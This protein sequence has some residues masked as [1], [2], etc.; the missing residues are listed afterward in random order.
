[1]KYSSAANMPLT[2][3]MLAQSCFAKAIPLLRLQAGR[4]GQVLHLLTM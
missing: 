2:A 3:T 1:M 4:Y